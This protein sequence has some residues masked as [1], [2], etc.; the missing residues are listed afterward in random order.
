[1]VYIIEMKN[2]EIRIDADVMETPTKHHG[3]QFWRNGPG[4]N[5]RRCV[6]SLHQSEVL[7]VR[8]EPLFGYTELLKTIE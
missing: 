2:M 8:V 7:M 1:M 3:Y 4:K 6:L 5:G